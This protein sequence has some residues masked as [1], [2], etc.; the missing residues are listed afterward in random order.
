MAL[1]ARSPTGPPLNP[2]QRTAARNTPRAPRQRPI[3]SGCWCACASADRPVPRR[4]RTV[5]FLTRLGVFGVALWGRFLR[6]MRRTSL[7]RRSVLPLVGGGQHPEVGW[8][9]VGKELCGE[10]VPD[11]AVEHEQLPE[12]VG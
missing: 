3:N 11:R 5:R 4:L 6:A 8:R 10:V 1:L 12:A 9:R 2:N 7:F